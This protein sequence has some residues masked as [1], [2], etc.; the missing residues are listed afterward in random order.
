M[1]YKK[2]DHYDGS[3]FFN[4]TA[5]EK[6]TLWDV[7]KM[8]A[9]S[10]LVKWPAHVENHPALRLSAPLG[11]RDV[12]L[13]FVGHASMLVQFAGVNVLTDPVWSSRASP[14]AF[15]GP[16]RVREPGI[17]FADLPRIDIVLVSHN[18]YDHM[19]VATLRRLRGAFDPAFVCALG[20]RE[21]FLA[22]GI[23]KVTELDWWDSCRVG[24]CDLTFVPTQHFSGRGV[25]DRNRALWGGFMITVGGVRVLFGG[26]AAYSSHFSAIAARLGSP[27]IALLPIGAY[28]PRWFMKL[29]HMNPDEAVRAHLDLGARRSVGIHFG[30]F[31]LTEEAIDQPLRDLEAARSVHGVSADAFFVLSEGRTE[32]L[33]V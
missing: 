6:Q 20:D 17:P 4:P 29:V 15:A 12:A 14:V 23:T 25:L 31:Q 22:L 30:C 18:H 9:T 3:R 8:L 10:R 16:R 33:S 21:K 1:A 19:D 11:P 27:D 32:I 5:T 2:S 7:A 28:D 13:T 26:D 24:P